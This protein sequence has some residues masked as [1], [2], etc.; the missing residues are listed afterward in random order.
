MSYQS[1]K[2]SAVALT[3]LPVRRTMSGVA[4]KR[5]LSGSALAIGAPSLTHGVVQLLDV[6]DRLAETHA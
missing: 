6:L 3:T 2:P 5:K 4:D 1:H